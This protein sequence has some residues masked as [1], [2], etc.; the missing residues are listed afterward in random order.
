MSRMRPLMKRSKI[1]ALGATIVLPLTSCHVGEAGSTDGTLHF[2]ANDGKGRAVAG[3]VVAVDYGSRPR[4]KDQI[5]NESGAFDLAGPEGVWILTLRD[6][7]CYDVPP[8]QPTE[9]TARI[10][11]L[12]TTGVTAVVTPTACEPGTGLP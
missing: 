1:A 8:V 5:T 9:V 3:V 12:Q 11:R 4:P 2:A 10:R 6:G 7:D